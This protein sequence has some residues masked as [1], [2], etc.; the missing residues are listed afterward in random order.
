MTFTR[1]E[2]GCVV[3]TLSPVESREFDA[4]KTVVKKTGAADG[5]CKIT[6]KKT[7]PQTLAR[8]YPEA[9]GYDPA[10]RIAKK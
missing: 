9:A 1:N 4:D 6:V 7:H 2:A 3:L 10:L 5:V 8:R